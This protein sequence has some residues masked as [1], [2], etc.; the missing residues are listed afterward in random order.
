MVTSNAV[1]PAQPKRRT[2]ARRKTQSRRQ[3][4][5]QTQQNNNLEI[6][7]YQQYALLQNQITRYSQSR[8]ISV[9]Q[10]LGDPL[11]GFAD[12]LSQQAQNEVRNNQTSGASIEQPRTM[13]AGAGA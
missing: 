13:T 10:S 6:S 8:H 11:M 7:A 5:T 1:Q 12:W 2:T 9:M 3:T 4:S